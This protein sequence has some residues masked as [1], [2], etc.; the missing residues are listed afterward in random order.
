MIV[1]GVNS[2]SS[3]AKTARAEISLYLI[4]WFIIT[5]SARAKRFRPTIPFDLAAMTRPARRRRAGITGWAPTISA[6]TR[7]S[8]VIH[9]A[10]VPLLV[11]FL[12]TATSLAA[13][14]PD[15]VAV[16]LLRRP[17]RCHLDAR[18]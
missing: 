12:A 1:S 15:R 7:L 18:Y 4:V 3:F 17:H 13:R 5:R 10:R 16:R 6:A 2:G 14:H 9:G 11:G 8:R